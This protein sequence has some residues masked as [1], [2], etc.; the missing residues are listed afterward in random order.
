M[1]SPTDPDEA[2]YWLYVHRNRWFS[3]L[4]VYRTRQ[5]NIGYREITRPGNQCA[6]HNKERG[7]PARLQPLTA[8]EPVHAS[9]T[10]FR[11]PAHNE[12]AY[13]HALHGYPLTNQFP[14]YT[15]L[16]ETNALFLNLPS[17]HQSDRRSRQCKRRY[18]YRVP[19]N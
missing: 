1:A 14:G 18:A 10:G 7:Y 6:G 11:R 19:D 4:P 2:P 9:G 8:H 3:V 17:L 5:A 13:K 15:A 12:W 16:Q